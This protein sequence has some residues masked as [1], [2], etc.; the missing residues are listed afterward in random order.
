MEEATSKRDFD[1]SL[2]GDRFMLSGGLRS[3]YG[4]TYEAVTKQ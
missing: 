1:R 3:Y 2:Q 4:V